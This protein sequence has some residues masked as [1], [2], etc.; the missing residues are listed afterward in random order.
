MRTR[1]LV[2][3]IA[4]L[5]GCVARHQRP[6]EPTVAEQLVDAVTRARYAAAHGQHGD[7]DVILAQFIDANASTPEAVEASYWRAVL[8]LDAATSR[9]DR[10]EAV[11]HLEIYLAD[12]S[13]TAHEIEA[14]LLRQ[15]LVAVDSTSQATDSLNAAARQA[16]AAREE[17]L[18]KEIQSLKDQL[19]KT[20]EE[21]TRIKRRLEARP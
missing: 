3:A 8:L 6:P 17:E 7:A 18:R 1:V 20:N 9:A 14:R 15:F 4:F 11:R 12:T 16:T 19:A 2:V 10:D 21:L 13:T 5:I